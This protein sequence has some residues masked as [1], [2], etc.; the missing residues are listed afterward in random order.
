MESYDIIHY[1]IVILYFYI[2]TRKKKRR[3]NMK[4]EKSILRHQVIKGICV[5]IVAFIVVFVLLI[6]VRIIKAANAHES[7][8][9]MKGYQKSA[10]EI[11]NK[12]LEGYSY[13]YDKITMN[14]PEPLDK[15]IV[16]NKGLKY[17]TRPD[18]LQIEM[19]G[20]PFC[21][22]KYDGENIKFYDFNFYF[23]YHQYMY[24]EMTVDKDHVEDITYYQYKEVIDYKAIIINTI[25]DIFAGIVF[26]TIIVVL[27]II[28]SIIINI[29][30]IFIEHRI[31]KGSEKNT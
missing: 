7:D 19:E 1:V 3:K 12:G 18:L 31:N 8:L 14:S 22:I 5:F 23:L 13:Y 11:Y 16:F 21:K 10:Y 6:V 15:E 25:K 2:L 24:I 29:I 9:T 30:F 26:L 4:K 20:D 27:S 17:V 28:I